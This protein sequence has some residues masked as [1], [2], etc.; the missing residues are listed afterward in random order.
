MAPPGEECHAGRQRGNPTDPAGPWAF[1]ESAYLDNPLPSLF[2]ERLFVHLSRLC[3]VR[4]CIIRHACFL[5]GQGRPAGDAAAPLESME[6]LARLLRR[7]VPQAAALAES[8]RRLDAVQAP[9]EIPSPDTELESDLFDALTLIFLDGNQSSR[10]R[11]AVRRAVGDQAAECL[12]VL[13]AFVRTA[14]YWTETHPA[15]ALETDA[16]AFQER[17]RFEIQLESADRWFDIYLSRV[18]LGR[19]Q[20]AAVVF[21]DVSERVHAAADREQRERA[22]REFVASA[23]HELR[24]PLTAVVAAIE[25]LGRGAINAPSQRDR[26]FGHVR[27]EATRLS[28][29]YDSLLLLG[30]VDSRPAL[31]LTAVRLLAMLEDIAADVNPTAG[32]RVAID[33]APD[34]WVLTN[35]GLLERVLTNLVENSAKY[36]TNG[37]IDLRA[38]TAGTDLIVEV[39]DTGEGLGLSANQALERF[40][41]V[42]PAPPMGSG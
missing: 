26:F 38:F 6:G 32:V 34:L 30:E 18:D 19:N 14:H 39:R 29:L 20:T 12:L 7:P 1:A 27:R 2:K 22:Q 3:E 36:T 33:V 42:A 40:P 4:Y 10:A 23:A 41:A 17:I 21:R 25:T 31:P 13:L 8:F 37:Q 24:M 15:L 5:I 11:T 35:R 28:C 16:V 9:T